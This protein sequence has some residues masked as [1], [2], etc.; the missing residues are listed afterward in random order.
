MWLQ[1]LQLWNC[2]TLRWDNDSQSTNT[3]EWRSLMRMDGE[4]HH[5]VMLSTVFQK[6]CWKFVFLK[7]SYKSIKQPSKH[8]S[9]HEHYWFGFCPR[10][11]CWEFFVVACSR[12]SIHRFWIITV[13]E[14][15]GNTNSSANWSFPCQF[16]DLCWNLWWPKCWNW[17]WGSEKMCTVSNGW[18]VYGTCLLLHPPTV[19]ARTTHLFWQQGLSWIDLAVSEAEPQGLGLGGTC[20]GLAPSSLKIVFTSRLKQ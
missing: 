16:I 6:C 3:P 17:K 15:T 5:G 7:A 18:L 11:A 12:T 2:S 4:P 8:F 13:H 10:R 19:C 14:T 20:R 1:I 9:H